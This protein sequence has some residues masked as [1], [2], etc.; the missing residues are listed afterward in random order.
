VKPTILLIDDNKKIV[1]SLSELL[2]PLGFKT[3]SATNTREAVRELEADHVD[4]VLL[5]IKLGE[6]NGID[7]FRELRR[8]DEQLPVI[9]IT[10]YATVD[11]AVE[12]MKL[13]AFDYFKKPLDF[14]RLISVIENAAKLRALATE[15]SQLKAHIS[16]NS[17]RY[18]SSK[19]R[20]LLD[21]A[22]LLAETELPVLILGENGT[23][24]E[25]IADLIHDR[26]RRS[27]REFH[28]INCAAFPESLL[29]NELFGHDK[30]SYT[31]AVSDFK[32]VFERANGGTLF[33]DEIGDMPLTIQAK[34]LRVL[35]NNEIRR[36]GGRET[37]SV[38]VRFIAATNK[39][40]SGLI[41]NA[42]F[43]EDLFYR[44]NAA[45]IAVPPLRERR[46]DLLPLCDYFLDEFELE[47]GPPRKTLSPEVI[48][49]FTSYRWPGNV[50]E[51]R[52]T[53]MYIAAVCRDRVITPKVLP[54]IFSA[55]RD[56]GRIAAP[57][58]ATLQDIER[59]AIAAAIR[60]ARGNKKQ[61]AERLGMS[62]NTL[63][64]K[65]REYGI[66]TDGND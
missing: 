44:L 45:T 47:N 52:N 8:R 3:L 57:E 61:T 42:L 5:D 24:K 2:V 63:Y 41:R 60:E 38:N 23:G 37:L 53:I 56:A 16:R 39:D 36:I 9:I 11:N 4:V 22:T 51:L 26:S 43:R 20:E 30:G 14:E 55:T 27:G 6:E 33:L 46:D 66:E 58:S 18:T 64:R 34:I 54:P 62:R 50:R 35:Q 59:Q 12:A 40:L 48:G 28:K 65:L 25:M 19:M 7:C 31:G 10:G 49:L 21:K 32:G 1:E 13:G 29:D 15:N 17:I